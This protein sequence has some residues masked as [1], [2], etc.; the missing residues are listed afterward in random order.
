MDK[1]C[2]KEVKFI[3]RVNNFGRIKIKG[4][5]TFPAMFSNG[6]RNQ[7]IIEKSRVLYDVGCCCYLMPLGG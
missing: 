1:E 4:V 3:Y 6:G 7:Q 5:V 2:F